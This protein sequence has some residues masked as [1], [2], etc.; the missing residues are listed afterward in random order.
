MRLSEKGEKLIMKGEEL[1][2]DSRIDANKG[3]AS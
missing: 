2:E 1:I 3:E